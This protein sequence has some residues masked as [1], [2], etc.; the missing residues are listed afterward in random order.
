MSVKYYDKIVS[1]FIQTKALCHAEKLEEL[2]KN[3]VIIPV[4]CEIDITDGFCNNKC[5]HCFFET[6]EKCQPII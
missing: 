5:K 6:N 1:P 3:K 4:T 2:Q